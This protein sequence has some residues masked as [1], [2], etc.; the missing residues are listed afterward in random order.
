M[1]NV[2]SI[3]IL[4]LLWL[5][6]QTIFIIPLHH[7]K[8][9]GLGNVFLKTNYYN[10]FL[11]RLKS[12]LLL[13]LPLHKIFVWLC[14]STLCFNIILFMFNAQ[15]TGG[16]EHESVTVQPGISLSQHLNCYMNKTS[17]AS[18]FPHRWVINPP[19]CAA[20]WTTNRYS[21]TTNHSLTHW[22]SR[23]TRPGNEL[24]YPW[25]QMYIVVSSIMHSMI[26]F[27]TIISQRRFLK[28][29]K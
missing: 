18:R 7:S 27:N 11:R 6:G 3:A 16:K 13:N 20:V 8:W 21:P 19:G 26:G 2:T 9:R 15:D 17:E 10:V 25:S 23:T 5:C 22:M 28:K 12:N 1:Y 24:R 4:K 14:C 29:L